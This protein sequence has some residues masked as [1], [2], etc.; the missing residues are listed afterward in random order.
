MTL[1]QWSALHCQRWMFRRGAAMD[2]ICH[3]LIQVP[4]HK[5]KVFSERLI[6]AALIVLAG[7]M[8]LAAISGVKQYFE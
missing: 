3:L 4:T 7:G 6:N 1:M 8:V 5:R 2:R